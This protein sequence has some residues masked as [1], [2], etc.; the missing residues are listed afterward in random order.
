LN[1]FRCSPSLQI[2]RLMSSDQNLAAQSNTSKEAKAAMDQLCINTIRTLTIDAVQKANS[3]HAGAPMALA[4]VAYVLWQKFLR[5]DPANPFWPNRDRFVLSVGHASMLLYSLL[6]LANVRVP[7]KQE[8]AVSLEDLKNFR[9]NRS[10]TPGHPE[11]GFT[12]GVETTT[13]PLGAGCGTSVGMAIASRWQAARYN[14]PGQ[15]LFDYDVYTLCSDGDMMEGVSCEAA[16]LAG[17]LRLSNLCWIY[18]S[19]HITI[20][21]KTD[22][23]YSE[24]VAKRFEAYGWHVLTV[25]DANDLL[26]VEVALANFK[27]TTDKPTLIIVRSIIGYGAPHKQNTSSAHSDPLGVEEVKLTKRFYDWPED[28]QFLVPDGVMDHFAASFGQRGKTLYAQW[29][30]L[31]DGYRQ[32]EAKAAVELDSLFARELPENWDKALPTFPADPKGM[33]TRDASG[34]VLNAVAEYCPWLIGGS[35]DLAPSN[36]TKLTFEGAGTLEA[37]TPGGRNMHFGIREHAMG[38]IVNGLG[39]C[40]LRA[41]GATFLVFSDY[42]RPAIR[43]GALME[44]PVFFIFTHDSI[45]VGEDGPTHQPVE[46]LASLRAMPGLLTLR[47]ADANEV[48]EAYRVIL[49]QTS[50]PSAL[51]LSRQALPTFDRTIYAPADGLARG[52]YILAD[53]ESDDAKVI[54]IASGS[55]VQLCVEVFERLKKEGKS[56]RVVSMASWELFEEQE[57][58]YRHKVLP[59][60]LTARVV[61]EQGS[62]LGWERYAGPSG[63]I[64]AMNS[65]GASA[66]YKVLQ[67]RFGFTADHLAEAALE[68]LAHTES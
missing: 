26:A 3:G 10:R 63:T 67:E 62:S 19:N 7:G 27:Q 43:L 66:P 60:A 20:E 35:A 31:F 38:A 46:H 65:F 58:A 41:F 2:E 56:V 42:M 5:Y 16:S 4:P 68:Q 29:T 37:T 8:P 55:E 39:L 17:H 50:R 21:G 11:Y 15:T 14:R 34:K 48:V 12:I 54:L 36:K 6:H 24:D 30:N 51:I 59:P 40:D 32:T 18:D 23:A 52:A 53:T 57:E 9:Q 28:A 64:I 1:R 47:P 22:L 13:G 49:A 25:A 61:I 33:A 44:L 45:G